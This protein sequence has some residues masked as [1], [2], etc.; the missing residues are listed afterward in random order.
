LEK[1]E[2]QVRLEELKQ[3]K[4]ARRMYKYREA[5]TAGSYYTDIPNRKIV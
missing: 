2:E 3:E 4:A 1:I 5:F